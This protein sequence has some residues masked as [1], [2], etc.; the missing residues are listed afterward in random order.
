MNSLVLRERASLLTSLAVPVQPVRPMAKMIKTS[1]GPKM[2]MMNT[3]FLSSV[4]TLTARLQISLTGSL[5]KNSCLP[6]E[7]IKLLLSLIIV[8]IK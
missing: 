4:Y 2:K 3:T 1:D 5:P 8:L 7:K 6:P